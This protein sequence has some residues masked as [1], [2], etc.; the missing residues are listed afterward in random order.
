MISFIMMAKNEERYI[1]A[2]IEA[3]Q[4]EE[5]IRWELVIVDDGSTDATRVI[6]EEFAKNDPRVRVFANPKQGKID[7]TSFGYTKTSHDFIK[8]IDADDVLLPRFFRALE[9]SGE[10]DAFCHAMEIVDEDLTHIADYHPN[11]AWM[12]SSYSEVLERL[13]SLPKS[14]WC[15]TRELGDKVFPLPSDLPFEDAW[16]SF[17]IKKHAENPRYVREPLYQ[18][19]QHTGQTFGGILNFSRNAVRFRAKRLL[20]LIDV[21]EQE[22]RAMEGFARGSLDRARTENSYLCGDTS[23][24]A[25]V[26][27]AALRRSVH[28]LLLLKHFPK[29][30][31]QIAKLKWRVEALR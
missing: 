14:C 30:T 18:Y 7:G 22:P 8:C 19:R 12:T 31:P 1:A 17:L 6:A 21:L 4:A 26:A 20:R 10:H 9:S 2:A 5:R 13:I 27:N 15:F 29:V 3:L 11:S 28:K 25:V 16:I 23:I 24:S